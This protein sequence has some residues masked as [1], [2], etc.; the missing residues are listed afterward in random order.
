MLSRPSIVTLNYRFSDLVFR[1]TAVTFGQK[2]CRP[3]DLYDTEM[4]KYSDKIPTKSA[5]DNFDMKNVSSN[6][7]QHLEISHRT[8]IKYPKN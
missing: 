8:Q 2:N 7:E 1:C 5:T 3:S 6:T 4:L